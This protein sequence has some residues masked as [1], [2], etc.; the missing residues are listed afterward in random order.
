MGILLDTVR[1]SGFRGISNLEMTLSKVTV[2]LGE[3]NAGKTSVIKALQ[4]ALGDYSR[5]LSDEDFHINQNTSDQK[6]IIIDVR[7][8]PF[9]EEKK[10]NFSEDWQQAFEDKIQSQADGQQFVVIRTI[11]KP[12]L[13]KGGYTLERY[14]LDNWPSYDSWQITN[15]NISNKLKKKLDFIP[16]ISID[17][18]R[19][20]H[21]ELKEKSS[22]IGRILTSIEYSRADVASL[23][24]MIATVNNTAIEKSD[25]LQKLKIHLD[26]LNQSLNSQGTTE[27]TPFPKKIR[28]FSKRFSVHYGSSADSSFSMEYHGMGTR[29]WASMLSVKAFSEL[30]VDKHTEEMEP[31]FPIMAAEEPE[32]HLHPNAQRTLYKQLIN[33]HGQVII[34]S[35]SPYIAGLAEVDEIRYL[36]IIEDSVKVFKLRENFEGDNLRKIK[37]EVIHSR[38]E[39][40]FSRAIVLSEGETEDQV[41]PLLFET[42]CGKTTFELGINFVAVNGS[43]AKY[44]PFLILAKDFDIPVFIFSDGESKTVQELKTNYEKVFG[45]VDLMSCNNITI[46]NNTDFEG[47]LLEQ[48]YTALIEHSIKLVNGENFIENWIERKNGTP[49]KPKKSARP[50]CTLCNQPI[51]ESLLRDYSGDEGRK[52]AILEILDSSKPQYAKAIA[53]SLLSLTA[54]E[55]PQ[56]LKDLFQQ[57]T[58]GIGYES[59]TNTTSDS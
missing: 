30:L 7:F 22:F 11:A 15:V 29:S 23:E 12:D 3:N 13:I 46:L 31:L 39:L 9:E 38:G 47:Y 48:N 52:R 24:Q 19:D 49:L 57:I 4:L 21:S 58:T 26:A 34:S 10:E 35:H 42:Y 28:D 44:L 37:R 56:K 16:F 50:P 17:A 45:S 6:Q 53:E 20:I 5:F 33:S 43:G 2:L 36:K 51:F 18:Q 55:L 41:L 8:I 32:A 40:L 54:D 14:H 27:L 1:I 59:L 25:P